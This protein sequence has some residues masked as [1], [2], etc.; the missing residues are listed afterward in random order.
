M[1]GGEAVWLSASGRRYPR[2]VLGAIVCWYGGPGRPSSSAGCAGTCSLP[3][4]S[5][6]KALLF[7]WACRGLRFSVTGLPGG[8]VG[9]PCMLETVVF[10][11]SA[12][13]RT[14]C[15]AG[16]LISLLRGAGA[17]AVLKPHLIAKR[18]KIRP[19]VEHNAQE[20]QDGQPHLRCILTWVEVDV[21][22]CQSWLRDG[23]G[24]TDACRAIPS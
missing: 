17:R 20:G 1:L 14:C 9:L 18:D 8:H 15:F 10:G 23:V 5:F 24:Q 2:G 22:H 16:C 19:N 6:R 3:A 4:P 12:S 21:R 7:R 13:E 11:H